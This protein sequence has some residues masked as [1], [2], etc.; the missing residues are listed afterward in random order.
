[1]TSKLDIHGKVGK[2]NFIKGKFVIARISKSNHSENKSFAFKGFCSK[3]PK[4]GDYVSI[5][6]G[7]FAE[8]DYG[9]QLEQGSMTIIPAS[10]VDPEVKAATKVSKQGKAKE[11]P[12]SLIQFKPLKKDVVL[13][14]EQINCIQAA[15][16]GKGLKI[17]AYAGTGKTSTLV[18]IAKSIHGRGLYL[19]YNKA[20]Q[21]DATNKFPGSVACK[22]AHSL[23]YGALYD[24]INGRV[25]NIT[26]INLMSHITVNATGGYQA[27]EMAFL[28]LKMLRA[29]CNTDRQNIDQTFL[30]HEHFLMVGDND[31]QR[32]EILSYVLQKASEYWVEAI[33]HGSTLPLE[34]DFYLKIYQL[35][36]PQLSRRF[37]YIL[38][39]ECQDANPVLIDILKQQTCQTI[40]VG[41]EH[42]QIYSWRGAVNAYNQFDGEAFYLSQSFRFGDKIAE[43]AS[44]LLHLKGEHTPLTGQSDIDSRILEVK[45]NQYTKLCRT[46]ANVISNIIDNIKKR[47]HVVGGTQE[48]MSLAKSGYAL[49]SGDTD[50]VTHSKLRTFRSWEKMKDFKERFE[51]PDI[52]FLANIIE[53]YDVKFGS[54]I[55]QIENAKYVK[56]EEA[57]IIFSTIHKAK[58][59]EWDHVVIGDDFPLFNKED[60]MQIML[61]EDAEEFNLLYVAITRAKYSLFLE[62][63]CDRFMARLK[64]YAKPIIENMPKYDPSKSDALP[65][66]NVKAED[67]NMP[68]IESYGNYE[69][70]ENAE[71]YYESGIN[72]DEA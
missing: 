47:I 56:E 51:D 11:A 49:F 34:H 45:P 68:P 26:P 46:N 33:K 66:N 67:H 41:D 42:Q 48:A 27:Y 60:D 22:T 59:R 2:V 29:F 17:K 53:R 44:T 1:M 55:T 38:F 43:L 54:V 16:A 12:T 50:K 15:K 14:Q 63:D 31:F 3:P 52:S 7:M 71:E 18:E 64:A 5:T 6:K 25:E 72:W 40:C 28:I 70:I 30:H 21:M 9:T 23:A 8:T 61:R 57:D 37:D 20:I 24:Q 19:A 10:Q 13:T 4:T 32:Q 69:P 35:T 62:K 39:D 58:G 65:E 36:K